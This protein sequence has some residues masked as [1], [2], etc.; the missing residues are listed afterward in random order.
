MAN[1]SLKHAISAAATRSNVFH[2]VFPNAIFCDMLARWGIKLAIITSCLVAGPGFAQTVVTNQRGAIQVYPVRVG[3]K[4]GFAKFYQ[5]GNEVIADTLVPPKYD[6]IGD[7]PLPWN[8]AGSTQ[9]PSPFRVFELDERVGL[10]NEYLQ[11]V[12]PNRYLRIRPIT[13]RYFA[14]EEDSLFT[15]FDVETGATHLNGNRFDDIRMADRIDGELR[16]FVR[17]G[18]YWGIMTLE[19]RELFSPQYPALLPSGAPSF[20]KAWISGKDK[21]WVPINSAGQKLLAQPHE[22]VL[23]ISPKLVAIYSKGVWLLL[24][25]PLRTS[26]R[27]AFQKITG[28]LAAINRINDSLF[29]TATR[30]GGL[31]VS[32]WSIGRHEIIRNYT[33]VKERDMN[34]P[35]RDGGRH[36]NSFYPWVFPLDDQYAIYCEQIGDGPYIERLIDY[37]GEGSSGPFYRIHTADSPG[38]YRVERR[39]RYGVLAPQ[40]N[41]SELLLPCAYDTISPL[42]GSYMRLY[43]RSTQGVLA[44]SG[45]RTDT[46]DCVYD[47]V[48][49]IADTDTLYVQLAQRVILY[50]LDSAGRFDIQGIFDDLSVVSRN[51]GLIA[52]AM[53]QVIQPMRP[54]YPSTG[55][56]GEVVARVDGLNVCAAKMVVEDAPTGGF[57]TVDRWEVPLPLDKKPP[58]VL[59][60]KA[61]EV[62]AF[63]DVSRIQRNRVLD[64]FYAAGAAELR[65]YDINRRQYLNTPSILGLRPFAQAHPYTTFLTEDGQMGLLGRNGQ[66]CTVDGQAVRYT[67]IGPFVA[68]RARVCRGGQ[69]I[70]TAG[71]A[72]DSLPSHFQLG[73][74]VSWMEEFNMLYPAHRTRQS[75][76][77]KRKNKGAKAGWIYAVDMPGSPCQWGYIDQDGRVAF[78]LEA[79][80]AEDYHAHDSIAFVLKWSERTDQYGRIA[81]D[82]G[83]VNRSGEEILP[84]QYPML[85]HTR[86]G[87]MIT[88]IN[89]P[90]FF[91]NQRGHELFI[92]PTRLRP[93]SEGF[94]QFKD[95]GGRWGYVDSTGRVAIPPQF[96]R[97]RPFS[98]GVALVA[99]SAG[100]CQYIR[101]TGEVAF[102]PPFT[103]R[104]WAGIGDFHDGRAWFKGKGW[105][106]G[107][108]DKAGRVVIAPRFVHKIEGALPKP[109]ELYPLPMDFRKG[110]A[111]VSDPKA[112]E[113][114]A[115]AIID[116]AGNYVLP[117]GQAAYISAFDG[118]GL[119]TYAERADGPL[120]LMNKAGE[121][122]CAPLY[123]DISFF[124][125]GLARV[126]G[127]N[128]LWGLIDRNGQEVMPPKYHQLG[129]PSEGLVATKEDT[130]ARWVYRNYAGRVMIEGAFDEAPPFEGGI[131][132]VMSKGQRQIIDRAGL[133]VAPE[134]TQPLF[135]SEGLFGLKVST[136]NKKKEV[137]YYSDATGGNVFGRSYASVGPFQ[138]GVAMVRPLPKQVGRREKLGAIN[139]RGVMVV[140]P[141]YNR[142]HVQP[143]GNIIINP[144]RYYGL[145]DQNGN[146]LLEPEYDRIFR[147]EEEG[148]YRV[149][150]GEKI[151]YVVVR[152]GEVI[153]AWEVGY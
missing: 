89:T 6:Y 94:A 43:S 48:I 68:G 51:T 147:Y 28:P 142:L 127:M 2:D 95:E 64:Q 55:M 66:E 113:Q 40:I 11:E 16:F 150:R 77:D 4:Y 87:I 130:Y 117:A 24:A 45:G 83:A 74:T 15:L 120:G 30:E 13:E 65:L 124:H 80:F 27:P 132:A 39:G 26:S 141:K 118:H 29:I 1:S 143:D 62:I 25:K 72:A 81:V 98:D 79:D 42:E 134:G 67:Y 121:K 23:V 100:Q 144:Q 123:K 56:D 44:V 104:Q 7:E 138:Y 12:L 8:D 60:V 36:D 31:G 88:K 85:S 122:L 14:V 93:F 107:A 86:E 146:I 149:E 152:G 116:T 128:G 110:V 37:S 119:G 145:A 19:G 21:G 103:A 101:Y 32:L 96:A 59:E 108:Y 70:L 82:Y 139:R 111:A 61:D 151:G 73:R 136:M 133:S 135:F 17:R 18:A 84:I 91:F 99:D 49:R 126:Q 20:Y 33:R 5:Y 137:N 90:T 102:E 125:K 47:N 114:K 148:L 58:K 54:V 78:D 50:V 63:H 34:R 140:P 46:L 57:Q 131:T 112:N 52:E 153:E 71:A 35:E 69:L 22:D 75:G 9:R 3:H 41:G 10:L 105:L 76:F 53:P 92:N 115:G 109:D 106:W 129:L 38:L 97:A